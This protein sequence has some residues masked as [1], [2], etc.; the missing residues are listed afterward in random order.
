MALTSER[1]RTTLYCIVLGGGLV[2]LCRNFG[3]TVSMVGHWLLIGWIVMAG[4]VLVAGLVVPV[5]ENAGQPFQTGQ[6]TSGFLHKSSHQ[7]P[8]NIR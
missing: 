8:R 7:H 5:W 6:K 2:A 4:V 1:L 3:I